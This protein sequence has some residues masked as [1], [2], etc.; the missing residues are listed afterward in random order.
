MTTPHESLGPGVVNK[1]SDGQ[2][3]DGGSVSLTVT[4]NWQL[5]ELPA[6]SETVQLTVVTPCGNVEPLGGLQTGEPTPEQLSLT[7]GSE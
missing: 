4:V 2:V 6:E 7:A 5:E 3:I 1:I